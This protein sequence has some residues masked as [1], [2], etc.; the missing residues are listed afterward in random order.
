M[1]ILSSFLWVTTINSYRQLNS[2][3]F[4]VIHDLEEYL[5]YALFKKEWNYLGKGIQRRKY[6]KLTLVETGVPYT[7]MLLY[8]F[9]ILIQIIPYL[10]LLWS[11]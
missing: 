9:L 6:K 11:S 2:G 7:F 5:P 10:C 4:K 1:G 8:G 3:K